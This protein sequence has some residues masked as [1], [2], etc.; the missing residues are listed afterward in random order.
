MLASVVSMVASGII[1]KRTGH[2]WGAILAGPMFVLFILCSNPGLII[3]RSP[4]AVG[5]GLLYTL[6]PSSSDGQL[7][8]YQILYGIGIGPAMQS[9]S[10]ALMADVPSRK[11]ITQS[12]AI[13]SFFQRLGGTIGLSMYVVAP[14]GVGSYAEPL[15]SAGTVFDNSLG[16]KLVQYAP[17][18]DPEPIKL[19]VGAIYNSTLVPDEYRPN[20]ILAYAKSVDYVFILGV[21]GA[22]LTSISAFLIV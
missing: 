3:P 5:A 13:A 9:W 11:M 20:V 14:V 18:V 2:Y 8:G 21:A 4:S 17:Q 15:N 1:V 10:V 7:I 22:A 6:S 19:S 16:K 12:I